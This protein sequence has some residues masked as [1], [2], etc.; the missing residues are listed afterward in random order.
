MNIEYCTLQQLTRNVALTFQGDKKITTKQVKHALLILWKHNCLIIECGP[1]VDLSEITVD[2]NGL[3]T[4]LKMTGLLYRLNFDNIL[5]RLRFGQILLY[6]QEK[7]GEL[8]VMI[9]EEIIFHGRLRYATILEEVLKKWKAEK[10]QGANDSYMTEDI[11]EEEEV[12]NMKFQIKSI[13]EKLVQNRFLIIVPPLDIKKR[14]VASFESKSSKRIPNLLDEISGKGTGNINANAGLVAKSAG[15][16]GRSQLTTASADAK[17]S[18]DELLPVELRL[19]MN[20]GAEIKVK[21]DEEEEWEPTNKKSRI[22]PSS[23][24]NAPV[25]GRG[26]RGGGRATG[27]GGRGRGRGAG[28]REEDENNF[29]DQS[30]NGSSSTTANGFGE[31]I[32]R[33][34]VYWMIGYD[35]FIRE[36][37]HMACIN[38]VSDQLENIAGEI[39]RIILQ[40]SM[41]TELGPNPSKS[42]ALS[43]EEIFTKIKE[44]SHQQQQ[45]QPQTST[46]QAAKDEA[47]VNQNIL[48]SLDLNTLKKLLDVMRLSSMGAI[49]RV[50]HLLFSAACIISFLSD[51]WFRS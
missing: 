1:E 50:S 9:G 43:L 37:R 5:N 18:K 49:M 23:S 51:P 38:I 26:G 33:G 13:F 7:H 20:S 16:R 4:K 27:R 47:A 17:G 28:V 44:Y 45:N 34:E 32:I 41:N 12:A 11:D 10:N 36:E 30:K 2:A 42:T 31:S 22:A 40:Q 25:G 6:I 35:Q 3:E 19:M 21:E 48:A 14:Y 8:G 46:S 29:P 39:V 15:K 24:S